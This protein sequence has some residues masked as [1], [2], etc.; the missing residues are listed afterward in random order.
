M[1]FGDILDKVFSGP[2]VKAALDSMRVHANKESSLTRRFNNMAVKKGKKKI[3]KKSAA[4]V[5]KSAPSAPVAATKPGKKMV[6][7]HLNPNLHG[8]AKITAQALGTNLSVVLRDLLKQWISENKKKAMQFLDKQSEFTD[9]DDDE[10][11]A[12]DSDTEDEDVE[13]EDEDVE[14][15]DEDVEDE[16]EDDDE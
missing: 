14:D 6:A 3:V 16:D 12:E 1:S 11:E 8:A 13:D 15:E 9:D 10:V 5:K 2:E 4:P 7:L